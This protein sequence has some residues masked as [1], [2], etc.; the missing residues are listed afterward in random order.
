MSARGLSSRAII[1]SYYARLEQG[2]AGWVEAL[3]MYFKSDQPSEEY[4]W[5]GM[6]PAMRQWVGGRLAK[7]LREMGVIIPNLPFE[8]T[9]E[10]LVDEMRRDKTGQV[11]VRINDLADRT[12]S[13]YAK[14]MSGLI[15]AAESTVCYDGQFYFDTDHQE[16]DSPTQ[17]NKIQFSLATDG[18]A[19]PSAERGTTTKPGPGIMELAML[20]GVETMLGFKDDQGEPMNENAA[21]FTAMFPISYT[22]AALAATTSVTLGA[23]RTN[24]LVAQKSFGINPIAN[25]RLP[26]TD[27]LAIFRND[28]NVKPFIRQEEVPVEM[29]AIAEGSELEFKE[30]KHQYGVY[31][32]RNV[33]YGYW[34][35]AVQVQIVA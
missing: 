8:A 2:A 30:R 34:Q 16:A 13:H 21:Q 35:Q 14:L 27:K 1:G 28:G 15:I 20:K 9:L 25:P 24:T 12:N 32:S 23:G 18:A 7:G 26:W 31:A 17:S 29:S 6:S 5:L 3:S 10:V 19:I 22:S 33:G 11:L 4:K